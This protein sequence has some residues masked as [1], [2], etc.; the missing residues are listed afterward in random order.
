MIYARHEKTNIKSL[1]II[2]NKI[3]EVALSSKPISIEFFLKKAPS[4]DFT[5]SRI[6]SIMTNTAP[7]EKV[8]LEENVK[9]DRKVD[10]LVSDS[11]ATA[12]NA[13]LELYNSNIKTSHLSKLLS[14]GLLGVKMQ[15]KLVPTRWSITAVDDII[16]KTLLQKINIIMKYQN[17]SY[18][19]MNIMATIMKFYSCLEIFHLKLSKQK[20]QEIYGTPLKILNLCRIMR[21]FLIEKNMQKM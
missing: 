13:I 18:L 4:F 16:S 2:Q 11:D 10:N 1:N 12:Q 15:R 9:V 17:F 5:P 3:Q 20:F 19:T 8:N 21:V 14:A 7:I 6:F